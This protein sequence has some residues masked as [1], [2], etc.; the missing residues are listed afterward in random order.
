MPIT[1]LLLIAFGLAIAAGG[2]LMLVRAANA[3]RRAEAA[4]RSV[5][6]RPYI[7]LGVVAVGLIIAYH[8]FSN[9]STFQTSDITIMFLFA[10]ALATLL[11]LRFFLAD[12][13]EL[14]PVDEG[15]KT[16]DES[17]PQ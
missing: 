14:P 12:K 6:P 16:N 13:L 11:G 7:P 8:S 17:H 5:R 2:L 15:R 3:D 10:L 1:Q 4:G 9:F